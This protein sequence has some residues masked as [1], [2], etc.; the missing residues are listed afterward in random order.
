V[1]SHRRPCRALLF[2]PRFVDFA[3]FP[4]S[5]DRTPPQFFS[6]RDQRLQREEVDVWGGGLLSS[7]LSPRKQGSVRTTRR[8]TVHSAPKF[9]HISLSVVFMLVRSTAFLAFGA[10][11]QQNTELTTAHLTCS[12]K[13]LEST[14]I[15]QQ[16]YAHCEH[17]GV[18]S[19][20]DPLSDSKRPFSPAPR[21]NFYT[22]TLR[23]PLVRVKPPS[24]PKISASRLLSVR[25]LPVMILERAL[26]YTLSTTFSSDL[27][28]S[29][30]RLFK[31]KI[32]NQQ[33]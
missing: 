7:G 4:H 10:S 19:R 33:L 3:S 25:Q 32:Y 28:A 6:T 24:K 21:N 30:R 26:P 23:T 14:Q 15:W 31:R 13:I 20:S 27:C 11:K 29:C 9:P 8:A 17:G 18:L 5:R 16:I 12:E 1:I 22:R 2:A